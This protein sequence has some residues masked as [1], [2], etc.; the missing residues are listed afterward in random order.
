MICLL[1]TLQSC[2]IH[3]Q[4][5]VIL[6]DS[7]G[8]FGSSCICCGALIWRQLE[9]TSRTVRILR[10]RWLIQVNGVQS[11]VWRWL[12]QLHKLLRHL[13]KR[14]FY[15]YSSKMG[16]KNYLV[17]YKEW[18]IAYSTATRQKRKKK[19]I[20]VSITED[21]MLLNQLFKRKKKKKIFFPISTFCGPIAGPTLT[22]AAQKT[23]K[24]IS[25]IPNLQIFVRL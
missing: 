9:A 5:T 4:N 19:I 8:T 21:Q 20:K 13:Q 16:R 22:Q 25:V 1:T 11:A 23:M 3:T 6:Y 14:L 15:T 24:A 2:L 17:N 7:A 18:P 12:V 10:G